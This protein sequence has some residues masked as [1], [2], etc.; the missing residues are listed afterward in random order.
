MTMAS[1]DSLIFMSQAD[2][3]FENMLLRLFLHP[4]LKQNLYSSVSWPSSKNR[5]CN[6]ALKDVFVEPFHLASLGKRSELFNSS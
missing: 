3:V 6:A 5:S 1:Y 4:W 2:K